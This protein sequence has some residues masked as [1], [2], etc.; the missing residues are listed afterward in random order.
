[1]S[2]SKHPP[3]R[4]DPT[5]STKTL[6]RHCERHHATT[7]RT[8]TSP[9]M[10]IPGDGSYSRIHSARQDD[11]ARVSKDRKRL[12]S[13]INKTSP[14]KHKTPS[15]KL[16]KYCPVDFHCNP[17]NFSFNGSQPLLKPQSQPPKGVIFHARLDQNQKK[18][19]P[20][21]QE[22][23]LSQTDDSNPKTEDQYGLLSP[24]TLK[25]IDIYEPISDIHLRKNIEIMDLNPEIYS[26]IEEKLF[27]STRHDQPEMYKLSYEA[28]ES[29]YNSLTKYI[30]L[31]DRQHLSI[32]TRYQQLL[33]EKYSTEEWTQKIAHERDLYREFFDELK[34]EYQALDGGYNGLISEFDQ[35]ELVNVQLRENLEGIQG[36]IDTYR[37]RSK[38]TSKNLERGTE[39]F[40]EKMIEY[41]EKYEELLELGVGGGVQKTPE[42]RGHLKEFRDHGK[43]PNENLELKTSL[44]SAQL[45]LRKLKKETLSYTKKRQAESRLMNKLNQTFDDQTKESQDLIAKLKIEIKGHVLEKKSLKR[46]NSSLRQSVEQQ[47][48]LLE[49]TQK[50]DKT[51]N[52]D[53]NKFKKKTNDF[54]SKIKAL[55]TEK[56]KLAEDNQRLE[57]EF[58]DYKAKLKAQ[59]DTLVPTEEFLTIKTTLESK[60][61]TINE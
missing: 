22:A 30:D 12:S 7:K 32:W 60:K 46:N 26:E 33:K 40:Y 55:E 24:G 1:M 36:R 51:S 54:Q 37:S 53:I 39:W 5:A 20:N 3:P 57:T 15:K 27:Q 2:A 16:P 61:R 43:S 4:R 23:Y 59:I 29:D 47:Q 17:E 52:L 38:D 14:K 48:S 21:I 45:E 42:R 19:Y 58:Q 41:K 13:K 11:Q 49:D 34:A 25:K 44:D 18:K 10:G 50:K 28:I 56:K 35:L 31:K 9:P 8:S 6:D